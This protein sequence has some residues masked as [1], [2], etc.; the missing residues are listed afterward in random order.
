MVAKFLHFKLIQDFT[1]LLIDI[2][3]GVIKKLHAIPL[4]HAKFLFSLFQ[5]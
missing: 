2:G 4:I 3:K 1:D 5:H